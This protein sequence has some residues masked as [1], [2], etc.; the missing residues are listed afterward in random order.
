MYDPLSPLD[1]YLQSDEER[2][3]AARID[4][5]AADFLTRAAQHDTEGSFP[6]EDL[7]A[8]VAIGYQTLTLPPDKGGMGAPLR[9]MLNLQERLA[10]GDPSVALGMGWHLSLML[11]LR[12][13][14]A[15]PEATFDRIADAVVSK[16]ALVNS[17]ASERETGSPSRGGRPT[18]IARE[19]PDGTYRISGRKT[20]STLSPRL[21]YFLVTAA[22]A[23]AE[24]TEDG[25][26]GEFLVPAGTPG[27]E[28][29]ET[30]N[31]MSLRGSGSHD[32]VLTEATVGPEALAEAYA[33]PAR[34]R[35]GLDGSGPLLHVAACYLGIGLRARLEVLRFAISHRPNSLSQPIST[36]PPVEESMG[37]IDTALAAAHALLYEAAADWDDADTPEARLALSARMG[38]AKVQAVDAAI[39]ACDLAMRIVGGQ[40]LRRELPFERLYRD[41]R[42]GLHNPPMTDLALRALGRRAFQAA[43]ATDA[44]RSHEAAE[45]RPAP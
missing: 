21:A 6:H 32:V 44:A 33:P 36:L 19:L 38:S 37:R 10:A 4:A 14:H 12:T 42:A 40:S 3:L 16:G 34:S 26:I 20:W 43:E 27:V 23:D 13:T 18:T 5:L 8:L 29:E 45:V 15:W 39:T 41:V 28:V 22:M 24:G 9:L 2:A 7:D 1:R 17:C 35:R 30:W 25:R 31:S 11:G